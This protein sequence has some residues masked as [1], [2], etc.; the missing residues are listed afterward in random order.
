MFDKSMVNSSG[1]NCFSKRLKTRD[2]LELRRK[3]SMKMVIFVATK[4]YI[5]IEIRKN[6]KKI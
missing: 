1:F 6:E 2:G 4:S 5:F 3:T